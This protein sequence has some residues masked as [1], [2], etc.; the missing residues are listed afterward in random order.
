MRGKGPLAGWLVTRRGRRRD[1]GRGGAEAGVGAG[2]RG[3]QRGAERARGRP[4][5]VPAWGGGPPRARPLGPRP[6][7]L[8]RV[9]GALDPAAPR[10]PCGQVAGGQGARADALLSDN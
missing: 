2:A 5:A 8:S 4:P 1:A 6:L 3:W 10:G 7:G 9:G